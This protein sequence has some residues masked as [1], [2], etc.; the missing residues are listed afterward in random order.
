MV[1]LNGLK[2]NEIE[3]EII[4]WNVVFDKIEINLI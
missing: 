2:W 3:E 1:D 4:R